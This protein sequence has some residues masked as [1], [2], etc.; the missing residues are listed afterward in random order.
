MAEKTTTAPVISVITPCYNLE[1]YIAATIKS[2]QAQT[3]TDWEMIIVDDCSIDDSIKVARQYAKDDPRIHVVTL[4]KNSGSSRARNEGLKR[5]KGRYITFIDGDDMIKPFKFETQIN[6]MQR[7]GYAITY[8]NYRR[9]T[10]DEKTTGILIRNPWKIDYNHMLKHSAIGTLTPIY[11]RE[12]VGEY[13]FDETLPARM[14]Y[15]FWLNVLRDGHIAYRFDRDLARY[16]RGH[17]SLSS[18]INWGRKIMWDIYRNRLDL[19]YFQAVWYYTH[20]ICH[21]L[22]KRRAY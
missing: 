18:N 9:I 5:A 6:F 21:A 14:D 4:D 8:T 19:N 1:N 13:F 10:P 3:M 12:V 2:V 7:N 11:D 20:Y 17:A 15:F 22:K 16:R